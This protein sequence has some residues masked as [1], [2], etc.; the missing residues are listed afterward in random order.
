MIFDEKFLKKI[1]SESYVHPSVEKRATSGKGY[2]LFAKKFIPL[3]EIVSISGG[4]IFHNK[5][6]DVLKEAYE[7]YAYSIHDEFTI[8]PLNPSDPSDD[9]RMNHC[10]EPNCGVLGQIIFVAI[11]DIHE[12]E[13]LTFDYAMTESDPNYSIDLNCNKNTC[14]KKFTGNDWKNPDLHSK[15][16]GFFSQYI[17]DKINKL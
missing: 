14:R 10:C 9:W 3:G 17:Q 1:K 7:D 15:Y 8:V 2:G 4:I 11:K 16:K 12:N 13:E 5:E 6:W